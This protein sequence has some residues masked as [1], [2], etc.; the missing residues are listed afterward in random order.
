M[1]II[2]KDLIAINTTKLKQLLEANDL[3]P[4]MIIAQLA[5]DGFIIRDGRNYEKLVWVKELKKQVRMICIDITK[6]GEEDLED[7]APLK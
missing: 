4:N 3:S 5:E 2:K 6:I 7:I 1:D